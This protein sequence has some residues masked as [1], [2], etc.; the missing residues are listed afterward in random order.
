[1]MLEMT[2]RANLLMFQ[3][4]TQKMKQLLVQGMVLICQHGQKVGLLVYNR[5]YASKQVKREIIIPLI[6]KPVSIQKPAF[7]CFL[8]VSIHAH[9]GNNRVDFG[10]SYRERDTFRYRTPLV[11]YVSGRNRCSFFRHRR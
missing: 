11:Q 9:I 3:L 5:R 8:L 1:M 7:Y 10:K 2:S 6:K 4:F